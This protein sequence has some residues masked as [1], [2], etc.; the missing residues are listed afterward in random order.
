VLLLLRGVLLHERMCMRVVLRVVVLVVV[1]LQRLLGLL[2]PTRRWRKLCLFSMG[3][4]QPGRRAAVVGHLAHKIQTRM[5][6]IPG[7]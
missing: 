3:A 7:S 6:L 4:L 1:V 5:D 2:R